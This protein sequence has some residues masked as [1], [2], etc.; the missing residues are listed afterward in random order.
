MPCTN[1]RRHTITE[2]VRRCFCSPPAPLGLTDATLELGSLILALALTLGDAH[3]GDGC[4]DASAGQ[5]W[6]S[7]SAVVTRRWRSC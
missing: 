4:V 5:P 1:H 3:C 6:R 7:S 2:A